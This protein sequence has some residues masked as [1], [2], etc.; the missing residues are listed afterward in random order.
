MILVDPREDPKSRIPSPESRTCTMGVLGSRIGGGITFL[1]PLLLVWEA[2]QPQ[3]L[4]FRSF[5]NLFIPLAWVDPKNRFLLGLYYLHHRSFGIQ[6][7]G[8]LLFGSSG[9]SE[10]VI[11][12]KNPKQCTYTS[13]SAFQQASQTPPSSH[14][15]L[16]TQRDGRP[17]HSV[18]VPNPGVQ[19]PK[20]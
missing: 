9:V 11:N 5:R 7:P 17:L 6:N 12:F 15:P 4:C 1:D 10:R 16:P 13:D 20:H 19:V 2:V 18:E 8:L 3:I 14:E